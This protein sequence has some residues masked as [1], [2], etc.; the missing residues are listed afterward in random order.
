M[1][2]PSNTNSFQNGQFTLTQLS[3]ELA[4]YNFDISNNL[5]FDCFD[6]LYVQTYEIWYS[7]LLFLNYPQF[8]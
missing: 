4:H 7:D 3:I 6:C 2:N 5:Q 1:V 8:I